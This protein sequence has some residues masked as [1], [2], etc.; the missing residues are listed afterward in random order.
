MENV[1]SPHLELSKTMW[2][3]SSKTGAPVE[4]HSRE[5]DRKMTATDDSGLATGD[6]D[7]GFLSVGN[8][9]LCSDT[10]LQLPRMGSLQD[11][12]QRGVALMVPEAAIASSTTTAAKES[13]RTADSGVVDVE[14]CEDL[15]RLTLSGRSIQPEPMTLLHVDAASGLQH[16]DGDRCLMSNKDLWQGFYSRDGDGDT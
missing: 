14:L 5:D 2:Y 10:G 11:E 4:E 3:S 7:S 13:V 8:M 9:Q 6:D 16:Q 1:S 15:N 12:G